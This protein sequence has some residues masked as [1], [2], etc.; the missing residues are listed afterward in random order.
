MPCAWNESPCGPGSRVF[1]ESDWDKPGYNVKNGKVRGLFYWEDGSLTH[2]VSGQ[3]APIFSL[4]RPHSRAFHFAWLNFFICFIMWFAIAPVMPTVKKARCLAA[5]SPMCQACA[6]EFPDD[7]MKW[8]GENKKDTTA[9]KGAVNKEKITNA[10]GTFTLKNRCNQ[11]YPYDGR[12][13]AGC[14]GLGLVGDQAKISTL[15]G[16]AGTIIL[17]I[18]IGAV[19]D[20]IG[21]RM[22]YTILLLFSC[23]PGFLLAAAD[24]YEMVVAMRFLVGFAGAS[25]VI[26]QLWTTTMFDLNCVG[27]AN[28]T[29]AGWGNLG[30]GVS[31]MI[32]GAIFR[33]CKNGGMNN[34]MAWRSTVAWSPAVIFLLGVSVFLFSDDCPYGNFKDLKNKKK[35]TEAEKE[36]ELRA[37]GGEAGSVALQSLVDAALD[38]RVWLLHLCYMFSFGVEL[39]V[40]GNIVSYFTEVFAMEQ[41]EASLIGSVFGFLNFFA[42]TLGGV[43]SDWFNSMFG[44]RGRITALT[45]QTLA[46]G[47]CLIA[48]STLNPGVTGRGGLLANLIAWGIMTN[49]TE[50]GTYAVVPYVNPVAMGGVSGIVGAGGNLGALLGNFMIVGL[51]SGSGSGKASRNLAFC[52]MGWGAV[53]S[54]ALCPILWIPGVGSM[55][56]A[57]DAAPA[58]AAKKEAPAQPMVMAGPQPTFLPMGYVQPQGP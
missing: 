47:V 4:A 14:G 21:I 12:T 9:P 39:I 36:A 35:Q 1:T 25:F 2:P 44:V 30:G 53:A 26:T 57:A 43:H 8:A 58:P 49:M 18:L 29:S 41:T 42:R 23:I 46:M 28:A 10:D 17:R 40:N 45:M 33:G 22:A 31:Q 16:I 11:C 38:W 27:I 6:L 50:G 54:A 24:S 13:G 48:F 5:D 51:K 52:A 20:G 55:F 32:N 15:V 56:R 19:A 3:I 37:S 7:N 34:E